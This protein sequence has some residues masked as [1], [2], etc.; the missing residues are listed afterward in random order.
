[1]KKLLYSQTSWWFRL[2]KWDTSFLEH[3]FRWSFRFVTLGLQIERSCD[4]FKEYR[5]E[6]F[7]NCWFFWLL[8]LVLLWINI[9][10]WHLYWRQ[11][12]STL[13]VSTYWIIIFFIICCCRTCQTSTAS[14]KTMKRDE[15]TIKILTGSYYF[16]VDDWKRFVHCI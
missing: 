4:G 11:I 13:F 1:M 2:Q 5:F 8:S 15:W 7:E 14:S 6:G 3:F 9:H 12:G 16:E 10:F